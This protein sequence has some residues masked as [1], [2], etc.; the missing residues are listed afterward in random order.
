MNQ[1]LET[2]QKG[3]VFIYKE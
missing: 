2:N 3:F 1:V